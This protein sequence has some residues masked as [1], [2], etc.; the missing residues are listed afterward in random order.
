MAF[1]TGTATDYYDL[2]KALHTYLLA[3]GWTVDEWVDGGSITDVSRLCLTAPGNV[4]GQQP[5][6]AFQL[7]WDTPT[8]AYAWQI[9]AY[10]T[11]NN[12]LDFGLQENCSPIAYLCLWANTIDYWFYVNDTRV[13][14]VAK[15]GT[16]YMS[17]YAG[18]FLPYALPDEYP[19]PYYVGASYRS[20]QP[21][22]LADAAMRSFCDP[23]LNSASYMRQQGLDWGVLSNAEVAVNQ[24]DAYG[25][26][27]GPVIWPYR[28]PTVHPSVGTTSDI[29][30]GFFH[31]MRPPIGG[32][33]P[34]WQCTIVDCF[35]ATIAGVLDGVF[36]TGGFNRTP[37]QIVTVGA[38]DYR[39]FINVGRNS[40]KHYFAV[41]E[42]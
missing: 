31:T 2:L 29:A 38:Q 23:G 17:A 32:K 30:W 39:L 37:E 40:P 8:N 6:V 19:Y 14:I 36:A 16:Y 13:I 9:T 18:F 35:D 11:Y 10:P 42:I 41:E 34:L 27:D 26:N 12:A 20:T 4:G 5:K 28:N 1:T 15:I 7:D 33:M 22:N 21:Y 25:V 3:Q 24:E